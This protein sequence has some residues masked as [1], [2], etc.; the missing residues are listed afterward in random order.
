M[1]RAVFAAKCSLMVWYPTN[2]WYYGTAYVY[3]LFGDPA[4]RIKYRMNTSIGEMKTYI[5][6]ESAY[7][8]PT[9]VR[10]VLYL[11]EE[12]GVLGVLF[13]ITGQKVMNL[14]P[15]A[16]DIR[17]LAPGVYFINKQGKK[18]FQRIVLVD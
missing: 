16:N 12:S 9:I 15:G 3:T 14:Y 13:D 4:L 8:L 11:P 6:S 5:S 2:D 18:V 1:G 7:S 17:H 10:S